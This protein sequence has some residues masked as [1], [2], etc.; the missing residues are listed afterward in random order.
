MT[1]SQQVSVHDTT[2]DSYVAAGEVP[3]PSAEPLEQLARLRDFLAT[4]YPQ[5][6]HRTN[7]QHEEAVADTAIRVM[8]VLGTRVHPME[9]R[10]CAGKNGQPCNKPVGHGYECGI[11]IGQ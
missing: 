3:A 1:T 4:Y 9:R 6:L 2:G 8:L 7:V 10:R 5:E 11:I